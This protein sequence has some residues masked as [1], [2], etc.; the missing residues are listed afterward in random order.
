MSKIVI[1]V[2]Y[3]RQAYLEYF[4]ENEYTIGLFADPDRK[5][6]LEKQDIE[7][8][9]KIDFIFPLNLDSK[10]NIEDSLAGIKFKEDS[11]LMC[12]NDR[13]LLA[14][15]YIAHFLNLNQK[16][17]LPVDLAKNGTDK[18]YQRKVFKKY[19]PEISPAYKEIRTFHGAY[20]FTRKHGFPVII[21]PANLSQ[22]Q[23]VNVCENLED[24]IVKAS[25]VLDH[26]AEVYKQN[27]VHA[28]PIV[29]IEKYVEGR[30]YSVDSYTSLDGEI[31]HTP[32]CEQ[33]LAYDQGKDNFETLYSTYTNS[34]SKKQEDLVFETVSKS[35]KALN[36]K[37]NPTHTEVRLTPEGGCKVIEV[38]IRTGGY[39]A[40]MLK[41]SYGI[42]HVEN[43]IKTYLNEPIEVSHELLQHSTCPQ[44]WSPV[45]GTLKVIKGLEEVEKLE[46]CKHL[47]SL[48]HEGDKVGPSDLGYPKRVFA[49]LAHEDKKILEEDLIKA[50][51][52]ITFE[53]EEIEPKEIDED[54]E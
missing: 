6:Y 43:V 40:E 52:L 30:Q 47:V 45:E 54:Q 1:F 24:L 25:Y 42:N 27:Q 36:I 17:S 5:H 51:S 4:V 26:V 50:R 15:A 3:I 23:L 53:V 41:Y 44:F 38:N 39:R 29:G 49:I 48:T 2:G 16:Q 11:L 21:K 35:I 37:G 10:K 9:S 20:L 28:K 7:S 22:S 33:A 19:F 46:S 31:V 32:V 34:L 13:Y 14:S 18:M 12:L 8:E